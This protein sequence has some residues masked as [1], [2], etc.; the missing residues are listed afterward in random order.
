MS[1]TTYSEISPT[2]RLP[3]QPNFD[4]KG[5]DS[6]IF[7]DG[8]GHIAQYDCYVDML[9][10]HGIIYF[11]RDF[12]FNEISQ[13]IDAGTPAKLLRPLI[14]RLNAL[15]SKIRAYEAECQ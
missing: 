11:L 5:E 10:S 2:R 13:K 1:R 9:Y 15:N 7:V 14:E 8:I 12:A 4:L 6:T 3:L